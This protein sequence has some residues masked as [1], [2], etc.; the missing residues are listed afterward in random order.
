MQ[1][2]SLIHH[3]IHPTC[4]ENILYGSK[5]SNNKLDIYIPR[6]YKAP[7][8]KHHTNTSSKTTSSSSSSSN[9]SLASK[10]KG[11]E[12]YALRASAASKRPIIVFIY[13]GAWAT[14]DKRMYAPMANTY[15]DRG[16]VVVVPNYTLHPSGLVGDML[17]D[18]RKCLIWTSKNIREYGGDPNKIFLVG[19]S[20]GAHL[21]ALTVIHDAI[22]TISKKRL[23]QQQNTSSNSTVNNNN[24]RLAANVFS[25]HVPFFEE[26]LPSIAGVVL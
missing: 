11:N 8:P 26:P 6:A 25:G 19:H 17:D 7:V 22:G 5:N 21:A 4:R 16:Y 3:T 9:P 18:V 20:A 1:K 10:D 23:A 15:R 14:G 2:H 13:G 12:G 24:T